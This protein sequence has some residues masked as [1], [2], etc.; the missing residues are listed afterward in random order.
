[1]LSLAVTTQRLQ[2]VSGGRCQDAQF[3]RGMQLQQFAQRYAFEGTEAPGMLVVK[4]LLGFLRRKTLDH[5]PIIL[6]AAL[7]VKDTG[8][9]PPLQGKTH[10]L[11]VV[12]GFGFGELEVGDAVAEE[13]LL[14][15]LLGEDDLGRDEE[16]GLAGCV[17]NG[18][19]D[20]GAFVVALAAFEAQAAAGY[21]L[22]GGD[23][24]AALGMADAGGVT[25][26]DARVL[27]AIDAGCIRLGRRRQGENGTEALHDKVGAG[28]INRGLRRRGCLR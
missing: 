8:G 22:A 20:E 26:L 3:R 18:D 7:Y 21:I 27:A 23:V 14:G 24:V 25:D 4:E 12:A 2:L 1:M 19:F 15:K 28:G 13:L 6:R 5:T 11:E 17:G 10:E 16:G 9:T